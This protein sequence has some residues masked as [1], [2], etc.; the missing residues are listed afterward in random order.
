M[1]NTVPRVRQLPN[2]LLP[3][4]LRQ[5]W[6]LV[7]GGSSGLGLAFA[8]ALASQGINVVVA[9]RNQERMEHV[10]ALLTETYGVET[11]TLRADLSERAGVEALKA[12]LADDARPISVL[13]NNAGAGLYASMIT[14]DFSEIRTAAEVMGL[15]PMEVGGAAAEHMLRRGVGLII[16][17]SSVSALV[18]M[19]AY[20]A[21]KSLVKVW[22]DSLAVK[23]RGTGV[24]VLTF[25]PGWVR[26]E[27]HERS[28]VSNESLP[29]WVWMDADRVVAETLEAAAKG[30]TSVT[31]SKR[32]KVISWLAVHAPQEAVKSAVVKL[33]KGR[34]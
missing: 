1:K 26:T 8:H 11:E 7:T 10:A 31:P 29:S 16:T 18:P 14:T 9:A 2:I 13:I 25:L 20:S 34:R 15:A 17:T 12:R 24:H 22:S 6:A 23:L 19:G 32:F 27:F 3:Q 33:N 30:K 28:G 21:I 4:V 5:G